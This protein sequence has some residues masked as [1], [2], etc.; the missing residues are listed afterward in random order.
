MKECKEKSRNERNEEKWISNEV[1][2][3]ENMNEIIEKMKMN[4]YGWKFKGK[5]LKKK[6]AEETK[7]NEFWW[8]KFL[9][10]WRMKA[11]YSTTKTE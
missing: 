5:G 7:M 10:H 3:N 6:T 8:R 1:N 11:L 4:D 9:F 2:L